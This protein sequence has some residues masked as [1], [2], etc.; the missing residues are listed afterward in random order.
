[1]LHGVGTDLCA[2]NRIAAMLEK[3]GD[4]FTA[5]ILTPKEIK[6]ENKTIAPAFLARRFA[7]KEAI[8]KALGCGIGEKLSFHDII[9]TRT[10]NTPPEATLSKEARKTFPNI[11]VQLSISDDGA[12]ALAFAAASYSS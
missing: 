11:N 10:G 8:A 7:A 5:R 2:I 4:T 1:M 3:H 6:A 12:Y 9:I